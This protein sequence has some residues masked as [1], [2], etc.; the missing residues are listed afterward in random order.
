MRTTDATVLADG[1]LMLIPRDAVLCL[2][3]KF[4]DLELKTHF[5]R[6]VEYYN[7]QSEVTPGDGGQGNTGN[8]KWTLWQLPDNPKRTTNER[9]DQIELEM[10]E[11][12][13]MLETIVRR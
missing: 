11:M 12:K 5:E 8:T 7:Q 4:P 3:N 1:D 9:L 10:R 13:A 2:H 6:F